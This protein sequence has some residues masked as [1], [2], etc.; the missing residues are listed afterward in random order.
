MMRRFGTMLR[1]AIAGGLL[2]GCSDG[3]LTSRE[4]ELGTFDGTWDGA[5]WRGTAYA[6]LQGDSLTVVGHR[7]DPKF[8]YDEYVTATIRFAGPGS[9]SV[10]EPAGQLS[11]ITGG[12]AGWMPRA[13]GTLLITAYDA[14]SRTVSGYVTL[15]ARSFDPEWQADGSFTAPVYP[16]LADVPQEPRRR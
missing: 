14:G 2:A 6:V 12:D 15:R 3:L 7:A 1:M 11:K 13:D 4:S 5:T 10:A 8:V 16:S 9:Y